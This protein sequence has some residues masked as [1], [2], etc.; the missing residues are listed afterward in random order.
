MSP[1]DTSTTPGSK[2]LPDTST[3]L[4]PLSATGRR[5]LENYKLYRLVPSQ[6]NAIKPTATMYTAPITYTSMPPW[7]QLPGMIKVSCH[8]TLELQKFYGH[9]SLE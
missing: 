5:N 8:Q 6:F 2:S 9:N 7:S 3:N 1:P 4:I